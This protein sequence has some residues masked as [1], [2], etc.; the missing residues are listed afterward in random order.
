LDLALKL[1]QAH[2][3]VVQGSFVPDREN[4]E[5]I[6]ALGN[7][8][9]PGCTRGIGLVPWVLGFIDEAATYRSRARSNAQREAKWQEMMAQVDARVQMKMEAEV[10]A[11]VKVQL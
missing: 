2:K 4:D 1:Q 10:E 11:R 9:H 5:L 3:E 6:R 7:K 8:K